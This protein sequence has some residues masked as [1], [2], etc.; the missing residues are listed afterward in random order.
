[1]LIVDVGVF[2]VQESYV[3]VDDMYEKLPELLEDKFWNTIDV[4]LPYTKEAE[5]FHK[6]PFHGS[7]AD[8]EYV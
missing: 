6:K 5:P 8:V 3:I 1:M 2:G 4:V 7:A